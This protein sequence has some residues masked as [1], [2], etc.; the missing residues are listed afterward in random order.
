MKKPKISVI[1]P[2]YNSAKYLTNVYKMLLHQ[3]FADFEVIF[4]DDFSSD[5]SVKL[6][7][8]FA[9]K[10]ER[11]KIIK[12]KKNHGAGY[13]RNCGLK[14]AEGDYL[15]FLDTDDFYS[16][17]MLEETYNAI[18]N[19]NVDIV[20]FKSITFDESNDTYSKSD[21]YWLWHKPYPENIV[22]S[23]IDMGENAM[24]FCKGVP[25]NKLYKKSFII[26]NKLKFQE[27]RR[28]NDSFF[29]LAAQILAKKIIII[30][31][32]LIAYRINSKN[33]IS[34]TYKNRK[35]YMMLVFDKL[36]NFMKKR[37]LYKKYKEAFEYCKCH[38]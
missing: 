27:I 35:D 7:K 33:S 1:I 12:L 37:N 10:D 13:A 6:L 23:P 28:H 26:K 29:V 31:K 17:H 21:V 18:T 14:K 15:I 4:V 16:T 11:F 3:T 36:Y 25:W 32:A 24:S 34:N 20:Y 5:N 22:F 2:C 19:S 38:F 8:N 9:A 30:D